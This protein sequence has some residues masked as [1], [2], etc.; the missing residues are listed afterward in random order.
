M[1]TVKLPYPISFQELLK[2]SVKPTNSSK[3]KRNRPKTQ[4]EAHGHVKPDEHP[5]SRQA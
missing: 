1:K 4:E 5:N 2:I 3:T